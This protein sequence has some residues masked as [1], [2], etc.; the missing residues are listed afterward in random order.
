MNLTQKV[1]DNITFEFNSWLESQYAGKSLEERQAL[2]AFFTPPEL[3]IQM[4]E[5][6]NNLDGTILDPCAGCGGLLAACIL[7]GA[8]PNNIYANEFD[9]DI[10]EMCKKRLIPMGVPEWHIHLGDALDERCY[11]FSEDYKYPFPKP[12]EQSLF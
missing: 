11:E 2:G 7:A 8:D 5:K 10:L 4:I 12:V 3:T 1:K 9:P 6:F